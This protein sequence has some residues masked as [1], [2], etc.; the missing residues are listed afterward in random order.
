M[1]I[2]RSSALIVPFLLWASSTFVELPKVQIPDLSKLP[3]AKVLRIVDG[4]TVEVLYNDDTIERKNMYK[5][6]TDIIDNVLI[7]DKY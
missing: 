4:D 7:L 5:Y 3:K 1:K 6:N 2:R